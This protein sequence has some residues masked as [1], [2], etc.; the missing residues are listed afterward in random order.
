MGDTRHLA[1]KKPFPLFLRKWGERPDKNPGKSVKAA[2][3][4][5]LHCTVLKRNVFICTKPS[6]KNSTI[7]T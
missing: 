7:F 4:A 1:N 6:T 2:V 3:V 5:L